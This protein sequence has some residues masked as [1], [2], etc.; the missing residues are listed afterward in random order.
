M[1]MLNH[2]LQVLLDDERLARLVKEAE[3]RGSSVATLVREA[4]D[5]AFPADGLSRTEAGRLL[6]DAEPIEVGD[7][8]ELKDEIE[9]MYPSYQ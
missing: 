4:I 7:W 5:T 8:S 2:R 1:A 6:L 3:R 9:Q